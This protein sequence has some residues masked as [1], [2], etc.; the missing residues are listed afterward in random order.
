M[1]VANT[2]AYYYVHAV[3]G[4]VVHVLAGVLYGLL[5][6]RFQP[7]QQILDEGVSEWQWQ[8][9]LTYYD[10]HAVKSFVV[11]VLSGVL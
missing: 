7:C 6:I 9:L 4:F 8:T 10:V 1:A 5:S 2:L 3:K 11:H